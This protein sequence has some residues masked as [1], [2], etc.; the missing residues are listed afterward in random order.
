MKRDEPFNPN[1]QK[2][3]T[4]EGLRYRLA[5]E[6]DRSTLIKLSAERNPSTPIE[7]IE[8]QVDRE[9]KTLS[10]DSRY[11]L[12]VAALDG[13]GV[14]GFCRFYHS[15]GLPIERKK[16]PA[17]EGWYAMGIFV[18]P[19]YRGRGV[20]RFLSERRIQSLKKLGALEYF[21]IVDNKNQTSLKMHKSFDFE[22]IEQAPGFLHI[23]FESDTGTLFRK[24]I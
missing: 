10:E 11:R 8:K 23:K 1:Q 20:A 17:P 21:T 16:F 24:R 2:K 22:A 14:I 19:K 5:N 4:P 15:G 12:Y 6:H 3:P 18:E 7:T 9:L 13:E